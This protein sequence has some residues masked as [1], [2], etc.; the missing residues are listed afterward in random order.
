VMFDLAAEKLN[1]SSNLLK[2][3]KNQVLLF[4]VMKDEQAVSSLRNLYQS[5]KEYCV[6]NK[7]FTQNTKRSRILI[8]EFFSSL[9]MFL[10]YNV[11]YNMVDDLMVELGFETGE[12][13][14]TMFLEF[15]SCFSLFEGENS[16]HGI[17]C[18]LNV[19][20]SLKNHME[21][22]PI[23]LKTNY[24]PGDDIYNRV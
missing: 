3:M 2:L 21:R 22:S 12:F 4:K 16:K 20:L 15:L 23:F 8:L 7:H 9:F 6:N 19:F 14:Q 18:C 13:F 11:L 17:Q 24:L 5:L 10:K 1:L